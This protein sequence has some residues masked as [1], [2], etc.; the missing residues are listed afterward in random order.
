MNVTYK[1]LKTWTKSRLS[2]FK[3]VIRLRAFDPV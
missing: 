3:K 1:Y 2:D